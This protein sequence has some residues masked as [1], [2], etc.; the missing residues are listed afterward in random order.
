[1]SAAAKLW[2][3]LT[4]DRSRL[5]PDRSCECIQGLRPRRISAASARLTG[6]LSRRASLS[7]SATAA[8][9]AAKLCRGEAAF[10]PVRQEFDQPLVDGKLAIR[11]QLHQNGRQQRIIGRIERDHRQGA[12][13]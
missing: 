6:R 4:T 9:A 12:Q 3:I 10:D 11:K 8:C 1:L 5:T 2:K 13:P 7:S